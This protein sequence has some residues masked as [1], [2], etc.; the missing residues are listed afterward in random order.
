MHDFIRSS[1]FHE[2]L[3]IGLAFNFGQLLRYKSVFAWGMPVLIL[4]FEIG[5]YNISGRILVFTGIFSFIFLVVW[6]I[7]AVRITCKD[8]EIKLR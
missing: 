6:M 2:L 5:Y 8:V 7:I 1:L 4:I 3:I